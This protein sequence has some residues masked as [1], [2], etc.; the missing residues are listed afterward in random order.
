M[1][2]G[3][4]APSSPWCCCPGS[5][6][7]SMLGVQPRRRGRVTAAAVPLR[8]APPCCLR[9]A[10]PKTGP[11]RASIPATATTS[12]PS[13]VIIDNSFCIEMSP[14]PIPDALRKGGSRNNRKTW[15]EH[16][17]EAGAAPGA[18]TGGLRWASET[19]LRDADCRV[20]LGKSGLARH[21]ISQDRLGSGVAT[22]HPS[23]HLAAA[24]PGR[25]CGCAVPAV[26][27]FLRLR[28]PWGRTAAGTQ[29]QTSNTQSRR[30]RQIP[31]TLRLV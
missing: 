5:C 25:M 30:R 26:V 21:R 9:V 14:F 8:G 4:R 29:P 23:A 13:G 22:R 19:R 11:S 12:I 3:T 10:Q 1:Q 15:T 28:C 6:C 31:A 24:C 20:D 18:M 27:L 16:E 7:C 2:E 17:H